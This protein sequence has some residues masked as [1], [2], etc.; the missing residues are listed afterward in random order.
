MPVDAT[1]LEFG[2]S[3][4]EAKVGSNVS[5]ASPEDIQL[6]VSE[7]EEGQ[8]ALCE[9][10]SETNTL[11][12][13]PMH[14]QRGIRVTTMYQVFFFSVLKH[15]FLCKTYEIDKISPFPD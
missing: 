14:C 9:G 12:V 1:L 3:L 7:V 10:I 11:Q 13:R 8:R 5:E 6:L 4:V 15:N 2:L